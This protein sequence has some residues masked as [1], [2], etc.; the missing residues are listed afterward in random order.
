[1]KLAVDSCNWEIS[2]LCSL[3]VGA[4]T[5]KFECC[6]L[7][8]AVLILGFSFV[9]S[10]GS[11]VVTLIRHQVKI[12]LDGLQDFCVVVRQVF[13]SAQWPL[14]DTAGPWLQSWLLGYVFPSVQPTVHTPHLIPIRSW[15]REEKGD[16]AFSTFQR[17]CFLGGW[18]L[19]HLSKLCGPSE[20]PLM[21]F[22]VLRVI[23]I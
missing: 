21:F 16:F 1:M 8:C 5:S 22:P 14:F 13:L 9:P 4:N 11:E 2:S 19:T 23:Y 6:E 10:Y 3:V 7:G 18:S 15:S 12:K 17:A 20:P